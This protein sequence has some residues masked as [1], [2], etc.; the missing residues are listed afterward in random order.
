MRANDDTAWFSFFMTQGDR[1]GHNFLQKKKINE[2][3]R[4]RRLGER[5]ERQSHGSE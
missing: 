3:I 5:A 4:I 2:A 1:Q